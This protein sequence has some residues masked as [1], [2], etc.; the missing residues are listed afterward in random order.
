MRKQGNRKQVTA[1]ASWEGKPGS[2][3]PASD[4]LGAKL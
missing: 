1:S 2:G 4:K 3:L